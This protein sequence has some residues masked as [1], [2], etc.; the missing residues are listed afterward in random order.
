[1]CEKEKKSKFMF[2]KYLKFKTCV[3]WESR[4]LIFSILKLI[5]IFLLA[6]TFS[7]VGFKISLQFKD[8]SLR[9]ICLVTK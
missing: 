8:Q 5:W 2:R 6:Q 7:F 9:E 3:F 4:K 1:M